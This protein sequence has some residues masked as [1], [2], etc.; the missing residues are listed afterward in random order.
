MIYTNILIFI[1]AIFLFSLAS[2]GETPA[3]SFGGS[4]AIY[5]AS[6]AG[7]WLLVKRVFANPRT[8]ETEGY[9][10]AEK[11]LSLAALLFFTIILFL[12]DIKYYVVFLS[13]NQ[14][15]PFLTNIG[16][17]LLFFSYLTLI[18]CGAYRS[19]ASVFGKLHSPVSFVSNNIRFNL[20][21][22]LPWIALSL[23][24]DL[25][26]LIPSS[27][28]GRLLD[29]L[30]GDLFFLG[31]FLILVLIFFPPLV[32]RLWGC[33]EMK[34]GPLKDHLVAFCRRQ[35]FA[36]TLCVWPLY[37]G[38]IITAAVLGMI[39]GL[40]Y[41]MLTPALMQ[42]LDINELEAVMAHEIG[43][44]KYRHLLLYVL[45]IGGFSLVAG[46]LAEPIL[47]LSLSMNWIFTLLAKDIVSAETI[48]TLVGGLPL[49]ILLLLYFRFVFGYFIRNFERQADLYVFK[50][51]GSGRQL[52]SA[53]EK[54]VVTSGQKADQPNWHHFGIGERIAQI[55]LCEQ[56]P[57]WIAR[58]D[59]KIRRSLAVYLAIVVSAVFLI[60]RVP[61]DQLVR[62]YEGKYIENVLMPKLHGTDNEASQYRLLGDLFFSRGLEDRSLKA[63]SK[64]LQLDPTN[65]ELLNNFAW[66]LL[67]SSD[68]DLRDPQRALTLA[69]SA[70]VLSP[71][72]HVL[73]TLA[74]AFWANGFVDEAVETEHRALER[75]S[76][77]APFYRQQLERFQN[78]AYHRSTEFIN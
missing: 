49:L 75:D 13:L 15:F 42:N 46:L 45:L 7:F 17:L 37:E 8:K 58:Q 2:S 57:S 40:R 59:R 38:R 14:R 19:Y 31:L 63:Y 56:D 39:P 71:L 60:D 61:A 47:Y 77:Q 64:A 74:T 51:L 11:K 54:I 28:L 3:I 32:K 1:A 76:D 48:I 65:P 43:H 22:V 55:E 10:A 9:F 70:A 69:R 21:I 27:N 53:F 29:S 26:A 72:P 16:G 41:I 68:Q 36:A 62:N 66:L 44:V 33:T 34:D 4:L 12:S 35:N 5:A 52:I 18:W 20:A 23:M 67:T 50:V 30:W 25:L 73:D 78:E 24:Y 6:L